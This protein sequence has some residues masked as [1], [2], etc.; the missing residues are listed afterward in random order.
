MI[1]KLLLIFS[2][3]FSSTALANESIQLISDAETENYIKSLVT[4]LVKAANLNPD[5]IVIRIIADPELNAF[6]TNGANIFINTGLIIKF[7]D[8]PNVLYGVMAHEIAHI[9]ASHIIKTRDQY[10]D[11]S[12]VAIGGAI[13][14]LASAFAGSPEA[15][16]LIGMSSMQAAQ[17]NILQYSRAN[18]VE[19]DKIAVE[20]LYKTHNN[21]EG[22]IKFF[23][24]VSQRDR[25]FRPDPY[26]ITHPLSN[27]RIASIKNSIKEKLGKFG[28]NI[29]PAMKFELKR[30]AVKLEAFLARPSDVINRYKNND[31]GLSIGYFRSGQLKKAD[32]LL[33]KVIAKE[34]NNPYLWEL[35]GQYNFENGIFD[36]ASQY[37]KKALNS[38]PEDNLIKLELALA[39]FNQAKHS[40]NNMLLNSSAQLLNQ[41][42]AAQ[43]DNITAYFTASRVYGL[44]NDKARAILAL[45]EYFFYQGQYAKSN[46][47]AKK[48]IKE[49]SPDSKEY[50]RAR[51]IIEIAKVKEYDRD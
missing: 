26:S 36:K 32:N 41:I 48:V 20:L 40:K 44:M 16:S 6:V 51:D 7:A 1:K 13:L 28:N 15:G 25:E 37:Y 34:P 30:I 10:D 5:N 11:M 23:Q 47:L 49:A 50:L 12:K 24:Y 38:L 29:T 17:S 3:F 45:S 31:Y 35:K 19:A 8:D 22:L 2:I 43:P 21:G 39:K 14:G 27:E 18:E 9:Y 4:P 33:N 42:I 46:I